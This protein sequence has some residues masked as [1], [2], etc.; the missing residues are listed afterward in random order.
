M[1]GMYLPNLQQA[2]PA[3]LAVAKI[4]AILLPMFSGFGADAI[5]QR[6]NDGNAKALITVDGSLRPLR[7]AATRELVVPR[8]MPTARRRW[9]GWGL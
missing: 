6:L 9:C 3:M 7:T 4:G 8:S 5:A 2:A 1:I